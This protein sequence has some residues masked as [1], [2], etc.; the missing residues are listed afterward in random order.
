MRAFVGKGGTVIALAHVNKTRNADGKPIYQ[1]TSDSVDDADCAYTI[2]VVNTVEDSFQGHKFTTKTILFENF[3]ARG[4]NVNKVSYTYTKRDGGTYTD[5][6]DSVRLVDE[7]EAEK[8]E[9]QGRIRAKLDEYSEEIK[10]V[11]EA[12]D[13]GINTTQ[14][15]KNYLYNEG[16]SRTRARNVLKEHTGNSFSE[17]HRWQVEKGEKNARIYKRLF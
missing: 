10:L 7:L 12:L 15:I 3:K 6:L 4:D 13:S 1:G 11:L 8:A 16:V 17:G 14:D 9:K 2:D 5:I